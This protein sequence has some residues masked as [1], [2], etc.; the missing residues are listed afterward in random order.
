MKIISE[1]RRN[2]ATGER[3]TPFHVLFHCK[4]EDVKAFQAHLAPTL[5][6]VLASPISKPDG[7]NG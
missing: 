6:N 5:G 4:E 1:A 7:E 2:W 3:A